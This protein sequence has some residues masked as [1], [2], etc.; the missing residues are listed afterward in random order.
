MM[1]SK[2]KNIS[3]KDTLNSEFP[4]RQV[5]INTLANLF[6]NVSTNFFD[7]THLKIQEQIQMGRKTIFNPRSF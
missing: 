1:L 3:I 5:Q 7:N 2:S 6:L 4:F